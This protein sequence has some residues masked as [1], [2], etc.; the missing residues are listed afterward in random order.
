MNITKQYPELLNGKKIVYVHGFLSSGATGTAKMLREL[1]PNTTVVADDIPVHPDEGFAMLQ[2]LVEREQPHLIVGTSMGGM[3]AERLRGFDRILVNPAFQM[4]DTM[5]EHNMMGRQTFQSPR[6]DGV[7][8]V[9][10][11]KALAKEYKTFCEGCF[12]DMTAEDRQQVYGLFGDED[13]VVHTYD[14]FREHYP[15]AIRFHGA[16]RLV[17]R[18]VIDYLVPVM[19]WIDDRQNGTERPS[20]FMH[21]DT[22]HD[23]YMHPASSMHKAYEM[24][25]EHYN[26]FIVADAPTADHAYMADVQAWVEQ[27][28][29][30]PAWN[31]VLFANQ[32]QLLY[33]DYLITR[34]ADNGFLGTEI[35]FGS[36]EFKSFE[37]VIVYFERLGGQ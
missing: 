12:A 31:H 24:L 22:L 13:P 9:M 4:G 37:D 7:Q 35:V 3:Y 28:L 2:A 14:L 34:R 25:L 29:S 33:G 20:V 5:G 26:V 17:D 15:Q 36:D 6:Q 23:S 32:M 16:H 18:V 1:L 10:V 19:R 21:I 11:T 30:A 27:Y 8:E